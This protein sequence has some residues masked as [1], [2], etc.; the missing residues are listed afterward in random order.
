[1]GGGNRRGAGGVEADCGGGKTLSLE[2][3]SQ[4]HSHAWVLGQALSIQKI[5]PAD[6]TVSILVLELLCCLVLAIL[7]LDQMI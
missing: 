7:P 3:R 4:P 2:H 1:M 6:Q 5:A